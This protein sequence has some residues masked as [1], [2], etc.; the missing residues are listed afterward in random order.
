M[1]DLLY[2][3][4]YL[5]PDKIKNISVNDDFITIK[6][7]II[8]DGT[9]AT[10]YISSYV[11][12]GDLIKPEIKLNGG[13]GI[14]K[15]IT[16][17]NTENI[18]CSPDTTPAEQYARATYPN[19]NMKGAVVHYWVWHD[20]IWQ[21]L[22]DDE[23]GWHSSDG[24][25][26]RKGHNGDMIGGNSDTIAIECIG[27]DCE[28]EHTAAV[29]SAYLCQKHNLNPVTDIYT[30]NYW[31]YGLDEIKTGATKNCPLYIL[32][33]WDKFIEAVRKVC[34][35]DEVSDNN[36]DK[37][38]EDAILKATSRNILIG[39]EKG[40]LKLHSNCSRQE[41]MVFLH[42]AYDYLKGKM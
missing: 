40:N 3:T 38:A 13:S 41:M 33:H 6:V 2:S 9:R 31:M 29:L 24:A 19:Q 4:N 12:E 27:S 15:G 1:E 17:H 18:S 39:D 35:Q 30:H 36:P 25:T 8:P 7:K 22:S 21:Q 32:P 11:N 10:K 20:D 37:W 16:I 42:R 23:Q 34:D 14:P 28:T 5:V 26:R